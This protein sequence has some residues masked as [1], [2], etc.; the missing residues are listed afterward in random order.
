MKENGGDNMSSPEIKH[1][2]RKKIQNV[3]K[4]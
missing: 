3:Q 2:Q 1:F 4:M